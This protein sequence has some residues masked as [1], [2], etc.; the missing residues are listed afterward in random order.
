MKLIDG[1]EVLAEY[2]DGTWDVFWYANG[3]LSVYR[4]GRCPLAQWKQIIPLRLARLAGEMAEVI[5]ELLHEIKS[6]SRFA[7]TSDEMAKIR[8]AESVLT[9]AKGGGN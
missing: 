3:T 9:K 4:D 6:P 2:L 1:E 7:Y 5:S 8:R